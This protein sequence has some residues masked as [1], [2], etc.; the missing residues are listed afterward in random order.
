MDYND[1][2]KRIESLAKAEKLSKELLSPL[3]RDVLQHLLD[4]GDVRPINLLLQDKVLSA[5]NLR[6]ARN[7]F[8]TFVP[9]ENI[10][11]QDGKTLMS[12]GKVK[13]AKKE[14]KFE[15][16]KEFLDDPMN[17]IYTWA[18]RNE[19]VT[20]KPWKIEKV[21]KTIEKAIKEGFNKAD[22]I[23]A[24]FDGGIEPK[25]V[26]SILEQMSKDETKE[27]TKQVPE[28]LM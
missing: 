23:R 25:D 2:K 15:A 26:I 9:F 14:A 16:I 19:E 28:A 7:F 27:E 11:S 4:E 1:L 17:N 5:L 13:P 18:N 3:S 12:F 6:T 20:V 24:V 21:S 8:R 22:I 10:M